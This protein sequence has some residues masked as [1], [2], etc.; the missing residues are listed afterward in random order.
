MLP[1]SNPERKTTTANIPETWKRLDYF[2]FDR[3]IQKRN[4][5]ENLM[6]TKQFEDRSVSENKGKLISSETELFWC[7]FNI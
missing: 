4:G 5:N 1:D 2:K 7:L 6:K 3:S